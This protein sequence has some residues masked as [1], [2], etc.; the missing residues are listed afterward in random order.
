MNVCACLCTTHPLR[1][2]SSKEG[3]LEKNGGIAGGQIQEEELGIQDKNLTES[4][5]YHF[6]VLWNR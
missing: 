5:K 4:L 6:E 3:D 2:L 1:T